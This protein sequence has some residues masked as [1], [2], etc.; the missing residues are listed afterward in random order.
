M[1][2]LLW[3]VMALGP[4]TKLKRISCWKDNP[5]EITRSQSSRNNASL[6]YTLEVVS[7]AIATAWMCI[8]IS[9][10]LSVMSL[11]TSSRYVPSLA[12][13]FVMCMRRGMY[14]S[15]QALL[16]SPWGLRR[17][18]WVVVRACNLLT[19]SSPESWQKPRARPMLRSLHSEA[20]M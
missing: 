6:R 1:L 15:S 12:S 3:K 2:A 5:R 20:S 10:A 4:S 8:Q 19:A 14:D 7:N 17:I 13:N 16:V 18:S 11:F 9:M